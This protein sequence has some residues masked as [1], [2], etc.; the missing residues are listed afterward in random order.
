MEYVEKQIINARMTDA[1]DLPP[2]A[3]EDVGIS[4]PSWQ[5]YDY[6][7]ATEDAS[8]AARAKGAAGTAL[9]LSGRLSDRQRRAP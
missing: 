4:M 6:A 1:L 7:I 3:L 5:P 8:L 2:G 9:A